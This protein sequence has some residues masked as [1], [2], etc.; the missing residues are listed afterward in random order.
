MRNS[1]KLS[2]TLTH[3]LM[4]ANNSND[5]I[6]PSFSWNEIETVFLDL[7]GTLLDKHF[8]DYFWEEY[9]PEIYSKT[10]NINIHIAKDKLLSTYKKVENTLVWTDLDYWSEELRLDIPLLKKKVNHLIAKRP[11]V[12]EFLTFL[13]KMEKD[14]YLVTNA[15]P[16]TIEVKLDKVDIEQHFTTIYCSKDAGAAKEQPEFWTQIEQSL[17]FSRSKTLFADD[18]EKVL[19]SAHRYGLRHLLH[20]AKPSSKLPASFSQTFPSI[21]NFDELMGN[22]HP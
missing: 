3:S 17:P 6:K 16:K 9:V 21:I 2:M 14:I 10:N 18:T 15:H 13:E 11:Q 19:L 7:D 1:P 5:Q 4:P 12:T 8:D 20:I 22:L